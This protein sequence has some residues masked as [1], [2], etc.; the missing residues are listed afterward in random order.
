MQSRSTRS[1]GIIDPKMSDTR[2]FTVLAENGDIV[3]GE[4]DGAENPVTL[5]ND[6]AMSELLLRLRAAASAQGGDLG[7]ISELLAV[8]AHI[9][10]T[11]AV[12][13]N[14]YRGGPSDAVEAANLVGEVERSLKETERLLRGND[15]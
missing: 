13:R 14:K 6:R 15:A 3:I 11:Y 9:S 7:P 10:H 1:L 5:L 4:L 2:K 12:T 8:I